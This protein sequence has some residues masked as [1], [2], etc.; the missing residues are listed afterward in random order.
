MLL[1]LNIR[2]NR[3]TVPTESPTIIIIIIIIII[4]QLIIIIM[5]KMMMMMMMMMM[6]IY[7]VT[8]ALTSSSWLVEL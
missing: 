3:L 2:L 8:P 6:M 5:M 4:I 1:G 7:P